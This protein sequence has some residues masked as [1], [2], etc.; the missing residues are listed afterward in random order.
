MV[1][2]TLDS[3]AKTEERKRLEREVEVRE[4][5]GKKAKVVKSYVRNRKQRRAQAA[6]KRK[7]RAKEKTK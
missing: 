3:I 1:S 4:Q 7:Q 2:G 6:A 5:Y